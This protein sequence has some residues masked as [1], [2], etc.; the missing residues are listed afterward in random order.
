MC[1]YSNLQQN[2]W[3]MNPYSKLSHGWGCFPVNTHVC[4]YRSSGQFYSQFHV[5][6][7]WSHPS[8]QLK[9]P[10][11][12]FNLPKT[13]S[14]LVSRCFVYFRSNWWRLPIERPSVDKNEI[15]E[16]A[17]FSVK[18]YFI[19]TDVLHNLSTFPTLDKTTID[20]TISHKTKSF[21]AKFC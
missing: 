17:I 8:V 16:A 19:L 9:C 10:V 1:R 3:R 13:L 12:C 11:N 20:T 2:Q 7:Y 4:S 15:S 18:Y 21:L 5:F 6:Y 14:W